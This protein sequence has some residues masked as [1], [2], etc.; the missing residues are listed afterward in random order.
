MKGSCCVVVRQGGVC[1]YLY[2]GIVAIAASSSSLVGKR[3]ALMLAQEP[4]EHLY[5]PVD[6]LDHNT[7]PWSVVI[8]KA[9]DLGFV[10]LPMSH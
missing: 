10:G 1:S 5:A 9:L 2:L 8:S 7:W 4:A 3:P 6:N